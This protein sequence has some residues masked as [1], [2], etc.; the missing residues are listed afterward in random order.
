MRICKDLGGSGRDVFSRGGV[1]PA[2]EVKLERGF[3]EERPSR[4]EP[5]LPGVGRGPVKL[6]KRWG[7]A[8]G[9]IK[10]SCIVSFYD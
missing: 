7:V 1:A 5:T 9:L 4:A 6:G 3:S 2:E 8:M 10:G